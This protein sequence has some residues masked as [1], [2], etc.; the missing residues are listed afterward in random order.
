VENLSSTKPNTRF[1]SVDIK[2]VAN[3]SL[4]WL[5]SPPVGAQ[6][7]DGIP[8]NILSGNRAVIH[9]RNR[10]RPDLPIAVRVPVGVGSVT[11]V[12]LLLN[13]NWILPNEKVGTVR[14]SY[15]AGSAQEIA[16]MGMQTIRETW[17]PT[18]DLFNIQFSPP[19][20]GVTWDVVHSEDQMR[21]PTKA[22]GFLDRLSI[23]TDPKRQI[24]EI[25]IYDSSWQAGSGIIIAAITLEKSP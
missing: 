18:A 16:L 3:F 14:V 25:S 17:M 20:S 24:D 11:A 10:D 21:G 7:F 8:F 12:H 22:T 6:R 19:P 2:D 4:D 5:V 23:E 15:R 9:T 1:V 13:G